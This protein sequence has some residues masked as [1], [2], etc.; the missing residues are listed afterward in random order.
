MGALRR[1]IGSRLLR[2]AIAGLGHAIAAIDPGFEHHAPLQGKA[3]VPQPLP[4]GVVAIEPQQG[5]VVGEEAEMAA[6]VEAE[7]RHLKTGQMARRPQHRAIAAQHQGQI[8][9]ALLGGQQARERIGGQPRG[10]HGDADALEAQ[11]LGAAAGMALGGLAAAAHNQPDPFK[12]HADLSKALQLP[13]IDYQR[14]KLK[15]SISTVSR[16]RYRDNRIARPTAAS[17][18]ATVMTKMANTC[19]RIS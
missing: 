12:T 13:D 4:Q 11:I 18:A 5:A 7:N 17:A 8:G 3:V 19:P 14:S 9:Q 2:T 16:L 10:G 6:D 15:R 1:D